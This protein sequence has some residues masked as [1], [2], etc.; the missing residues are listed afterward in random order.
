M[1]EKERVRKSE[2]MIARKKERKNERDRE[3]EAV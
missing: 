2:K 1:R 3:G